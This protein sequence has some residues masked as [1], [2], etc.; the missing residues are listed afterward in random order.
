MRPTCNP[1]A[2]HSALHGPVS[3]AEFLACGSLMPD[4]T[5]HATTYLTTAAA[6]EPCHPVVHLPH[7]HVVALLWEG[8]YRIKMSASCVSLH[9]ASSLE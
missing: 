2:T 7:C 5:L 8:P 1:Y 9:T 3:L 4:M 6:L